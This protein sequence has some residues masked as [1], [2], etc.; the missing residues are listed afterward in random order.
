MEVLHWLES[1]RSP[2]LDTLM[3][4]ITQLG[5]DL[6][7][8]VVIIGTLW[9]LDKRAGFWMF[10]SWGLGTGINQLVKAVC[11]IPRPWVRD[12][13]LKA[14]ESAIPAATGY[15]FPS[16]HTQSVIGLFGSLSVFARKW[17]VTIV[18]LVLI[19]LT[20]FSRMYL[21][22]HTP[23]D[24][25]CAFAIGFV[26]VM[27][28]R[29]LA[30]LE[31]KFPWITRLASVILVGISTALLLYAVIDGNGEE[32][33]LHAAENGWKMLGASI[34]LSAAWELDKKV[35][36]FQTDAVWYV[37]I[38]K[39]LVGI[40]GALAIQAGLKQ[41]L[42][43]LFGGS[44]VAHGVRY[45]LLTVFAGILYPLTFGWWAKLGKKEK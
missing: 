18:S 20:G 17:A 35:L 14:V 39:F 34:G 21:G 30:S 44:Y 11:K 31:E 28:M 3:G 16:G 12:P 29:W 24:V 15:S 22:V 45:L 19:L 32:N 4:L 2:F 9:C 33:M 37:Q 6:V 5:E 23:A 38:A 42:L 36:H 7:F 10:F 26:V 40:L 13:S 41:P 8:T 43:S 25:L 1:I 27:L